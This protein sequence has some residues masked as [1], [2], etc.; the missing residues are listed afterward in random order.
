MPYTP[1]DNIPPEVALQHAGTTIYHLYRNGELEGGMMTYWFTTNPDD[2][3]VDGQ[4]DVRELNAWQKHPFPPYAE[5]A[6]KARHSE[7]ETKHI[8]EALKTAI[9]SGELPATP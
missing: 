8:L 5:Y 2:L 9:D 7:E 4:F 1:Q 6:D 3:D